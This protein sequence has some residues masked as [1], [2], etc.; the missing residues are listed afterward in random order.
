V[1]RIFVAV[2]GGASADSTG[3]TRRRKIGFDVS[4]ELK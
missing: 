2:G 3:A 4:I 1:S